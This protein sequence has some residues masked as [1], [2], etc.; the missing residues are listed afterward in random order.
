MNLGK[1]KRLILLFWIV[2]CKKCGDEN[3]HEACKPWP[4]KIDN[5]KNK[6]QRSCERG[7]VLLQSYAKSEVSWYFWEDVCEILLEFLQESGSGLVIYLLCI[8]SKIFSSVSQHQTAG[9]NLVGMFPEE[10]VWFNL[11]SERICFSLIIWWVK[12][13]L[14]FTTADEKPQHKR[15]KRFYTGLIFI[16][17]PS[18]VWTPLCRHCVVFCTHGCPVSL[19]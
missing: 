4:N 19:L 1:R 15:H 11:L 9:E 8:C 17:P 5:M 3:V 13:W 6:T 14:V 12:T 18:I 10:M 16:D 2:K 7:P